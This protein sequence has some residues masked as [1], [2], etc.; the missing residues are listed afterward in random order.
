MVIVMATVWLQHGHKPPE[1]GSG[2]D[3]HHMQIL[4]PRPESGM[5][6][7]SSPLKMDADG[8]LSQSD[9]KSVSQKMP[10]RPL[11]RFLSGRAESETD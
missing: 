1:S 11:S 5:Q 4:P 3:F 8:V 2:T 6:H 10:R 7:R 9:G